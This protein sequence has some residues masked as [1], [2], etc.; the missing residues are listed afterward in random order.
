MEQEIKALMNEAII[1]K[2]AQWFDVTMEALTYLGAW[3]SFIYEYQKKDGIFCIL[4][5]TPSSHRSEGLIKGELDWILY[6]A[7]NGVS[8]SIPILSNQGR[9]TEIIYIGD[10]YFTVTS[11]IK[12]EGRKIGYP[13]C[14]NDHQLYRE[15]GQI[16]G[17]MHALSQT[18]KPSSETIRRHDWNENYY[19]QN[20]GKYVPTEQ[21]LVHEG[22]EKLIQQ[23]GNTL[24]K[25][26]HCYGLIHGDI[27]V[28]NFLVSDTGITLFDFDEAQYSWF[29]E[30]I[31]VPL[32]YLVYV[33]GGE[34]GGAK[35]ASQASRFMEHFLKGYTQHHS[36]EV[37]WFKQ[38]PLFLRLREIIVYTGMYRSS[39]LTK[40]NPWAQDYLAQG[41]RRIENGLPI[42][43]IWT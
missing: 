28:G 23:I 6:L 30:D 10:L 4:R 14:L 13:E 11:F 9:L 5:I 43:D 35:R 29:V 12:A 25:N 1:K 34:E 26:S 32:Y 7:D 41:R 3:Q 31:A 18:Y 8:V 17:N 2:G 24:I 16:T 27:G 42:V 20:I 36:L 21:S 22:C 19:L 37:Y 40:L 33:Y 38:I 39:D 15:L